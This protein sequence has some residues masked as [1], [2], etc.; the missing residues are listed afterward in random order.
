MMNRTGLIIIVGI[1]ALGGG[2]VVRDLV[3][4]S[5]VNVVSQLKK[6]AGIFVREL[7][8]KPITQQILP[9]FEFPDMA[10]KMHS[11][12]E[13]QGKI[14]VINFWATWCPPCVKE[15]PDFIQL[16]EQYGSKNLQFIGIAVD[17]KGSV[18]EFLTK[19]KINYPILIGDFTSA[20]F[21]SLIYQLGNASDA[22]PFTVIVNQKG[23]IL[24]KHQGGISKEEILDVIQPLMN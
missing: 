21:I 9:E 7:K 14:R 15:I 18:K 8:D 20:S 4:P 11:S 12:S 5:A 13:W 3:A 2:L 22:I 16:Q 1:L 17:D 6:K 24:L 23:D 10:D 19:T